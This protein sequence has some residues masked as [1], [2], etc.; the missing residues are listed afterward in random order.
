[1]GRCL[2]QSDLANSRQIY[3]PAQ[4]AAPQ[5]SSNAFA[6]Y[7]LAADQYIIVW[8]NPDRACL[9]SLRMALMENGCVLAHVFSG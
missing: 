2:W 5:N 1:M 4:S 9:L 8:S 3:C 6:G 7:V